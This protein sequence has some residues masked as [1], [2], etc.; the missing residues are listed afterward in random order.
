MG[1]LVALAL[2]GAAPRALGD[3][4]GGTRLVVIC[5]DCGGSGTI[6]IAP[7]FGRVSVALRPEARHLIE[8]VAQVMKDHPEVEVV[9]VIGHAASDERR[10]DELS[11]RRAAAVVAALVDLGIS[12]KRLEAHAAGRALP[13]ASNRSPAGRAKNRRV[14]FRLYRSNG[15]THDRWSPPHGK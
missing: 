11:T 14:E 5:H 3:G 1:L 7:H 12:P 13:V 4:D 8:E 6:L 15:E 10:P 2:L 9:G